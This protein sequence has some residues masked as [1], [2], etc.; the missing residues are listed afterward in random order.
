MYLAAFLDDL[1]FVTIPARAPPAL[2]DVARTAEHMRLAA[3]LLL[4][5]ANVGHAEFIQH[6]LMARLDGEFRLLR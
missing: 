4:A 5:C 1:Y 2:D 6:T 3:W